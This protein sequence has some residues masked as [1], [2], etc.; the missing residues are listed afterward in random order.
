MRLKYC[1]VCKQMTNHE[2]DTLVGWYCLKCSINKTREELKK[3]EK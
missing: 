1:D 2:S 3:L